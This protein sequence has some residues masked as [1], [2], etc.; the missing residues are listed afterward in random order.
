MASNNNDDVWVNSYFIL[1]YVLIISRII[2][3]LCMSAS[4]TLTLSSRDDQK[5][6]NSI[7]ML[8]INDKSKFLLCYS[9]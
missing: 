2:S 1:F 4:F 8:K 9:T 5:F 6:C 3:L 7:I